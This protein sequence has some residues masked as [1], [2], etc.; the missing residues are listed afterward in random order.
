MKRVAIIG[1]SHAGKF[2]TAYNEIKESC[3]ISIDFFIERSAGSFPLCIT[4]GGKEHIFEDILLVSDNKLNIRNFDAV[5]IIGLGVGFEQVTLTYSKFRSV[6]H[7]N[8]GAPY[9]I[10]QDCFEASVVGILEKSKALRVADLCL[11]MAARNVSIVPAPYPMHWVI[12]REGEAYSVFKEMSEGGDDTSMNN[13]LSSFF[14]KL[15]E[16]GVSVVEQPEETIAGSCYTL[17][18]FGLSDPNQEED[19]SSY[20]SKGD[21]KHGN[22][23]FA[24]THLKKALQAFR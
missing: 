13:L 9:L 14:G 15:R 2:Y 11:D 20:Y 5:L 19:P 3:G 8:Q 18:E 21:Y 23:E 16:R 24:R 10:S 17:T 7:N 12:S 22:L 6:S 4:D 1:N